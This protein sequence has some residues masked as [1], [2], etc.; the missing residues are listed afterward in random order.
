M[1]IPGSVLSETQIVPQPPAAAR[2]RACPPAADVTASI[3][4]KVH[5]RASPFR[6]A[7]TLNLGSNSGE[8]PTFPDPRTASSCS[9]VPHAPS[10]CRFRRVGRRA[11]SRARIQLLLDV[12]ESKT[13][14]P[15]RRNRQFMDGRIQW[16]LVSVSSLTRTS[17]TRSRTIRCR[18]RISG[19]SAGFERRRAAKRSTGRRTA[20]ARRAPGAP[21]DAVS[22]SRPRDQSLGGGPRRRRG[23][24]PFRRCCPAARLSCGR[25]PR[26]WRSGAA[27]AHEWPST[28]RT[29]SPTARRSRCGGSRP[30]GRRR[31]RGFP[32]GV[33]GLRQQVLPE[34][35][36]LRDPD[37]SSS[38][39]V[40]ANGG[41]RGIRNRPFGRV[42]QGR[43]LGRLQSGPAVS[44]Q[45]ESQAVEP[46]HLDDQ[47]PPVPERA[48]RGDRALVPTCLFLPV[49]AFK[50]LASQLPTRRDRVQPAARTA[51]SQ[52]SRP[53]SRSAAA[54]TLSTSRPRP[55]PGPRVSTRPP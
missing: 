20:A 1:E 3:R 12:G 54:H 33:R 16:R 4:R 53:S 52:R 42:K 6:S 45:A 31:C 30:T 50:L 23:A 25:T 39:C 17:L 40:Y 34:T 36:E 49:P 18:S 21:E 5:G 11:P 26:G 37:P 19:V 7:R 15:T 10:R 38:R 41:L 29:G 46:R 47:P 35:R 44:E 27:R 32:G 48:L 9:P 28:A 51:R 8:S 24:R 22:A 43:M 14:R 55:A 13:E 2:L